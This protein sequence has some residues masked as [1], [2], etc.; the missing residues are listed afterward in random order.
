MYQKIFMNLC[1]V[2][3][4]LTAL[5]FIVFIAFDLQIFA[6]GAFISLFATLLSIVVGMMFLINEK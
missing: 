4:V 1:G 5:Q 6:K 3:S 2:L